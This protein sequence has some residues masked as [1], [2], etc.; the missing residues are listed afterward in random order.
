M[1]AV[2]AR[3]DVLTWSARPATL[4]RGSPGAPWHGATIPAAHGARRE[5]K[6]AQ[7]LLR[8]CRDRVAGRGGRTAQHQRVGR[9]PAPFAARPRDHLQLFR[10]GHRRPELTGQE[11]AGFRRSMRSAMSRAVCA[12]PVRVARRALRPRVNAENKH[13]FRHGTHGRG[14]GPQPRHGVATAGDRDHRPQRTPPVA[15]RIEMA[16]PMHNPLSRERVV[17]VEALDRLAMLALRA[18]QRRR[19]EVICVSRGLVP[20]PCAS[21]LAR[22]QH[23]CGGVAFHDRAALRHCYAVGHR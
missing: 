11:R 19:M 14:G 17:P 2:R 1:Q 18:G 12:D 7:D 22:V 21:G 10:R 8:H 3:P 5:H 15:A 4:R 9:K 13:P 6:G 23:A 16:V 20:R